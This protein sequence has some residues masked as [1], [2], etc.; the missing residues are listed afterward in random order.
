MISNFRRYQVGLKLID[1]FPERLDG[2]CACGCNNK[3]IGRKKRWAS[4]SCLSK[5]LNIFLIIKGDSYTIRQEVFERDNGYCQK[6]GVY[7]TD[8]NADHIIPVFL[9]GSAC[10]LDNFQTL[11]VD[12]HKCKT[13]IESQRP[14]ISSQASSIFDN[15]LLTDFGASS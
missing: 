11:C 15:R 9:G 7:S 14:T 4:E 2:L 5:A 13:Y 12:C 8:W 10:G 3:L 6:C 1:L